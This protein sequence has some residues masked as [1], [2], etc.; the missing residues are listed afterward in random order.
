MP[1]EGIYWVTEWDDSRELV[2]VRPVVRGTDL[3]VHYTK[4]GVTHRIPREHFE[5]L[6]PEPAT[7][8]SLSN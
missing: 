6:K 1:T 8:E 3:L 2:Y 4:D 7:R 5:E